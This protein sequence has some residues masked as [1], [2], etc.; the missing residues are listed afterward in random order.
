ME[1]DIS[2]SILSRTNDLLPEF[3]RVPLT[4][5]VL[6]L[7]HIKRIR[8][9]SRASGTRITDL[10]RSWRF[11]NACL[12]LKLCDPVLNQFTHFIRRETQQDRFREKTFE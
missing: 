5:P 8:S 10:S 6:F 3:A 9:T 2:K 1:R 4:T 11:L 7:D 12:P